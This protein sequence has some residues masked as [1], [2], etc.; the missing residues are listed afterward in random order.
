MFHPRLAGTYYAMGFQYGTI[1]HKH[2][3]KLQEQPNKKLAF[4]RECKVEVKKFFP[5][6]L[7]EI[8][9][10]A[11]ACHV[12]YENLATLILTVGAFKPPSSCSVFA[13]ST[14][15]DI[16]FGRNYD[17]Y[18]SFKEHSE[19]Y[20]TKPSN[21]YCSLGNTDIFVGRED[22]VNEKGLAIGMTAVRPTKVKP[23]INFALLVRF[24]LD[25]CA[26]VREATKAL[27]S[28]RHI[29]ANNYLI[30]D[31]EG[32]MDVVEACPDRVSVRKPEEKEKFIVCTNHFVH[33]DM[34]NMENRG[35]RPPDSVQRYVAI[36]EKLQ[37]LNGKINIEDAQ[38]I[39][40]DHKG[41]V[42]SHIEEIKLGTLWSFFATLNKPSIY[43]AEGH[44]C[45]TKYKLDT[46]LSNLFKKTLKLNTKTP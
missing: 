33:L 14:G 6:V 45:R 41:L 10:F 36:H 5:E 35:E 44:P 46:R 31:R 12:S 28:A 23:G 42:C 4:G 9:G 39:L 11:D 8:H 34:H 21:G 30:A 16:L 38:K 20:L 37:Q 18:Y 19:S 24:I 22:G 2:G 3:F 43:M 27:K 1:L 17:F 29:T 13:T 32:N 40:S 7:D 25:K 15:S 26:N